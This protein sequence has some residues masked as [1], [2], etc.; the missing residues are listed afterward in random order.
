MN[1]YSNRFS[2]RF[3]FTF[4]LT[5][6]LLGLSRATVH[7]QNKQ[8]YVSL[9]GE[10][11]DRVAIK[12]LIDGYSHHADRREAQQQALLF[13]PDGKIEV[14]QAEPGANKPTAVIKG[15]TDLV[16]GFKTLTRYDVTMHVNGQSMLAIQGD[17]ATGETY[18]LAHHLLRENGQRMLIVMGIRYYDTLVRVNQ[19]WY[20]AKRQLIFDWTDKRPSNPQE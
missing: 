17:T 14:F 1:D 6:I 5:I 11:A 2:I 3:C 19:Q 20:F 18:C 16:T 4:Q 13:T 15:Q 12:A 7:A 10:A 8:H 9:T